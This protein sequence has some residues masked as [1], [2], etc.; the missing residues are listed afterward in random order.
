MK[1]EILKTFYVDLINSEFCEYTPGGTSLV[2]FYED[3]F[4]SEVDADYRTR[5]MLDDPF[6]IETTPHLEYESV[7]RSSV[8]NVTLIY[9]TDR[10]LFQVYIFTTGSPTYFNFEKEMQAKDFFHF[11]NKWANS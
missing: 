8:T 9:N 3:R 11:A 7:K 5:D 2:N 10:E 1:T 4:Y 6:D